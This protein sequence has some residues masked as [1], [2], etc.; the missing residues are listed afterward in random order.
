M[1]LGALTY[2]LHRD[3]RPGM[4]VVTDLNQDRLDRAAAL[5]PPAQVKEEEGIDLRFV[6]T[7]TMAD[8]AAELR[9]LTGG[10]GFDDVLCYAPV[11]AVVELSSAVLGRDGCLNFFAGPTDRN[12]SAKMNFYD[13]HYNSTHVMGT[14][15]G[16]T[17]DM[18]ESLELTA[19]KRI[20]PAVM[21]THIGG[22]D[23]AA[24]TTLNLPKIPGGK[25]LI[26][27]HL[28]LPL[29]ALD[30]LRAKGEAEKD[31]RFTALADIVDS[32]NGLWCP[33]AEEFLLANFNPED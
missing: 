25:K 13:V 33:E 24:E 3:V 27:T 11:G 5:F 18:I 10:T 15:G 8:P 16:N 32:H 1:G 19:A 17:D 6:N 26:Y 4:V 29:T 2:A 28:T 22:L 7:G 31:A 12:F 30:G 9:E 20:N 23:A 21:V 14:T